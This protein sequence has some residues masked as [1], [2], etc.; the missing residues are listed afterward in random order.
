MSY[1]SKREDSETTGGER[2]E[3]KDVSYLPVFNFLRISVFSLLPA[4]LPK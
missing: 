2:Q 3:F 4:E 1:V